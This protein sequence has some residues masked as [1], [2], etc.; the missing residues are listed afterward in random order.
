CLAHGRQ[1]SSLTQGSEEETEKRISSALMRGDPVIVIDNITQPI[2]GDKLLSILTQQIADLRPLGSSKLVGHDTRALM[3]F[4]GNNL[5]I[6]GDMC[7]R[8]LVCGIDPGCE[9][10]ERRRFAFDPLVRVQQNR[11][12]YV[13]A[14]LTILRAYLSERQSKQLVAL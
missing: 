13:A 11:G 3:L 1:P 5:I 4:N 7:R 6:P 10:P 8:L 12:K 2:A 9:N 14:G